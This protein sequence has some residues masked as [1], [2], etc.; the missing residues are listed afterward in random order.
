M[1]NKNLILLFIILPFINIGFSSRTNLDVKNENEN[2]K[3]QFRWLNGPDD[4]LVRKFSAVLNVSSN[5]PSIIRNINEEKRLTQWVAKTKACKIYDKTDN[6]WITYTLFDI[7][8]P[9]TQQ[10]LVLKHTLNFEN[11]II[12]IQLEPLPDYLPR[13]D[14]VTRLNE[15]NGYWIII[16]EVNN[17]MRVEFHYSTTKKP[18]LPRFIS[19]PILQ[20]LLMESFTKLIKLSEANS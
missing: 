16:P 6:E 11:E 18:V 13:K 4:I 10:D 5:L 9:L 17:N 1:R 7:P 15:Y 14:N 3:L 19:E 12:R 2:V 8:R 20:K